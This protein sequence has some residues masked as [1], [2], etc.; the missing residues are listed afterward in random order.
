MLTEFI[1]LAIKPTTRV[2]KDE[3][4]FLKW[5]EA[6]LLVKILIDTNENK[7]ITNLLL[8]SVIGWRSVKAWFVVMLDNFPVRLFRSVS[9]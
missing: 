8:S 3:N 5:N 6:N 7:W 1:D 9:C 2:R 4:V